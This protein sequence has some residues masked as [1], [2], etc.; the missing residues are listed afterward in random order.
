[1]LGLVPCILL[2]LSGHT[3]NL[4][5]WYANLE[6]ADVPLFPQR[7]QN[8]IQQQ[9]PT[10]NVQLVDVVERWGGGLGQGLLQAGLG[11][12]VEW[13][14]RVWDLW[15]PSESKQTN[16]RRKRSFQHL[17]NVV[18]ATE[19]LQ[20]EPLDLVITC[21][22]VATW[23]AVESRREQL[24][25]E[26]IAS[27]P[28]LA[29]A[30]S[31]HWDDTMPTWGGTKIVLPLPE[32]VE[33][34]KSHGV[35]SE[36]LV[37]A[38]FPNE[39]S[40]TIFEH[41]LLKE[42]ENHT[43]PIALMMTHH[44]SESQLSLWMQSMA[45]ASS[46]V[47]WWL[48]YDTNE[49]QAFFLREQAQRWGLQAQMFGYREDL[50]VFLERAD[51]II[52]RPKVYEWSELLQCRT[53]LVVWEPATQAE[54]NDAMF[55]VE[56]GVAV[57]ANDSSELERCVTTLHE[58]A[59]DIA[60]DTVLQSLQISQSTEIWKALIEQTLEERDAW[61]LSEA[62]FLQNLSQPSNPP[63]KPAPTLQPE[64]VVASGPFETI[65]PSEVGKESVGEIHSGLEEAWADE[66]AQLLLEE[67]KRQAELEAIDDQ[68]HLWHD[69]RRLAARSDKGQLE[70]EASQQ[71]KAVLSE[72]DALQASWRR[73]Q[74]RKQRLLER[75]EQWRSTS[76]STEDSQPV[77]ISP[78]ERVGANPT[79][80]KPSS[81]VE[82][83]FK[84]LAAEDELQKLKQR[85]QIDKTRLDL[86]KL[87]DE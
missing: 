41:D 2:T 38:P 24:L 45:L 60:W 33:V 29:F 76:T 28:V 78:F 55:F 27:V 10:V 71:Y 85:M 58:Q 86:S 79:P 68:I 12:L 40:H 39:S 35:S 63:T 49:E 4:A 83:D 74:E 34:W 5:L 37:V 9:W 14:P 36:Q 72:R 22:P 42:W 61:L 26:P 64:P 65:G 31:F 6:P 30:P 59:D 80:T 25:S 1:M 21:H 47:T 73:I 81:R 43:E 70:R 16:D 19:A 54:R 15:S 67:K 20:A 46:S 13:V 69:R 3:M 50:S 8:L 18:E 84:A 51:A 11:S 48:Y 7:L 62:K 44:F 82:D 75:K 56:S 66:Y 52:G 32:L 57:L 23:L 17:L 53:P 87:K 77:T